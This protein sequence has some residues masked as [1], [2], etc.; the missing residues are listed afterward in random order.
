MSG[1][2]SPLQDFTKYWGERSNWAAQNNVPSDALNAV[3]ALDAQRLQSGLTPYTNSEAV[4]AL[5]AAS[6]RPTIGTVQPGL[7]PF[8]NIASDAQGILTGLTHLPATIAGY[9]EHPMGNVV[10]PIETSVG[11]LLKGHYKDALNAAAS[12]PLGFIPGVQTASGIAD[13]GLKYVLQ[14]PLYTALDTLPISAEGL[15]AGGIL[16]K[17]AGSVADKALSEG[18]RLAPQAEIMQEA[19]FPQEF[20]TVKAATQLRRGG[21]SGGYQDFYQNQITQARNAGAYQRLLDTADRPTHKLLATSYEGVLNAVH[22]ISPN[23]ASTLMTQIGRMANATEK[24]GFGQAARASASI[25]NMTAEKGQRLVDAM[26]KTLGKL[27]KE[28]TP[29]QQLLLRPALEYGL[30]PTQDATI[31]ALTDPNGMFKFTPNQIEALKQWMGIAK[32]QE[33]LKEQLGVIKKHQANTPTE[34]F[35][36]AH[37]DTTDPLARSLL[38]R[39]KITTTQTAKVADTLSAH[40]NSAEEHV[41]NYLN[42][43][44]DTRDTL[45]TEVS[46]HLAQLLEPARRGDLSVKELNRHWANMSEAERTATSAALRK[47]VQNPEIWKQIIDGKEVDLAKEVPALTEH[48][49]ALNDR[50]K[51]ADEEAAKHKAAMDR[52]QALRDLRDE[53]KAREKS[54]TDTYTERANAATDETA[55]AVLLHRSLMPETYGPRINHFLE[56]GEGAPSAAERRALAEVMREYKKA[57]NFD[58][59]GKPVS[60]QTYADMLKHAEDNIKT[61]QAAEEQLRAEYGAAKKDVV[62]KRAATRKRILDSGGGTARTSKLTDAQKAA[63]D[64]NAKNAR[65][66]MD[67]RTRERLV[68]QRD[69]AKERLDELLPHYKA[70][71]RDVA[72][73]SDRTRTPASLYRGKYSTPGLQDALNANLNKFAMSSQLTHFAEVMMPNFPSQLEDLYDRSGVTYT[74][75]GRTNTFKNLANARSASQRLSINIPHIAGLLHVY[76][77]QFD[78]SYDPAKSLEENMKPYVFHAEE[79]ARTIKEIKT[80]LR[81]LQRLL[82]HPKFST[83]EDVHNEVTALKA[84]IGSQK[85][86]FSGEVLKDLSNRSTSLNSTG[87]LG[88]RIK[89]AFIEASRGYTALNSYDKMLKDSLDPAMRPLVQ[90][91]ATHALATDIKNTIAP[92]QE[93]LVATAIAD[94]LLPAHMDIF[95]IG[96]ASQ[97]ANPLPPKFGTLDETTGRVNMSKDVLINYVRSL[98]PEQILFPHTTHEFEDVLK[99]FP[100]LEDLHNKVFFLQQHT[101]ELF[102]QTVA[103][104]KRED[105]MSALGAAEG[106]GEDENL[107][108]VALFHDLPLRTQK[109]LYA[110]RMEQIIS[111]FHTTH[112]E[113]AVDMLR[114]YVSELEKAKHY[115]ALSNFQFLDS[116]LDPTAYFDNVKQ[117]WPEYAANGFAPIYVHDP[118]ISAA[119]RTKLKISQKIQKLSAEHQRVNYSNAISDIF[120]ALHVQNYELVKNEALRA[121]AQNL[122]DQNLVVPWSTV[123]RSV[124]STNAFLKQYGQSAVNGAGER[125]LAPAAVEAIRATRDWVPFDIEK[126]FT[127]N[128]NSVLDAHQ[129]SA[130]YI[131]RDNLELFG[132]VNKDVLLRPLDFANGIFKTSVLALSPRFIAHLF[133]GGLTMG[134]GMTD[135]SHIKFFMKAA[136]TLIKGDPEGKL[137]NM[138]ANLPAH[139]LESGG[140][141]NILH[142]RQG[143]DMASIAMDAGGMRLFGKKISEMKGVEKAT[144]LLKWTKQIEEI[145]TR[146]HRLASMLYFEDKGVTDLPTLVRL[147]NRIYG[148]TNALS[149]LE[150]NIL[151]RIIPFYAFEAHILRYLGNYPLD[152][153]FRTSFLVNYA[154]QLQQDQNTNLPQSLDYLFPIINTGHGNQWYIDY[155]QWN[156]FRSAFNYLTLTGFIQGVNPLIQGLLTATGVSTLNGAATPYLPTAFDTLYASQQTTRNNAFYS[157]LEAT[158]PQSQIVDHFL[159]LTASAQ[160]LARYDPKYNSAQ[161]LA[162]LVNFPWLPQKINLMQ[163]AAKGS[164]AKYRQAVSDVSN[165]LKTGNFSILDRYNSD[166]PYSGYMVSAAQLKAMYDQAAAMSQAAPPFSQL[167]LT[168]IAPIQFIKKPRAPRL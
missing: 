26:Q 32:D 165:A 90:D 122:I 143:Q 43:L 89:R 150:R 46:N 6:G 25:V 81:T 64:L 53:L 59:G 151:R 117:H 9:F 35:V 79:M 40:S 82:R 111:E 24:L 100:P 166:V 37:G 63:R 157:V 112:G 56:T 17:M 34:A 93:G 129:P 156:P 19:N 121:I 154:H 164:V 138:A 119:E 142:F 155:R 10:N 44:K 103:D 92:V 148:D 126:S 88:G 141:A 136:A 77:H 13:N 98:T 29:E 27:S 87:Y 38:D 134:V 83:I 2:V 168:N 124:Q 118:S 39:P 84:A 127:D 15:S 45:D 131:H 85:D 145:I 96:D 99:Q 86:L 130:Y 149:P 91:M 137:A 60:T 114:Q 14:H 153:P 102:D 116:S 135:L 75:K 62:D 66:L 57:T 8:T 132:R 58:L 152:H 48:V 107:Q 36:E 167:G 104:M 68:I 7:N 61:K 5:S 161:S 159:H 163:Y 50:I 133:F 23:L 18:G 1:P 16:D 41:S 144:A 30:D 128:A 113:D 125:V 52:I 47:V 69:A 78:F 160:S 139:V 70:T 110:A 51:A 94:P 42:N 146:T 120:V 95:G 108:N 67:A 109:K 115:S 21:A 22:S 55:N 80:D 4:Q 31:A 28:F 162:S 72:K 140:D 33:A 105:S 97:Y 65:S 76:I 12:S 147:Q 73:I 71:A 3:Y 106:A 20:Q 158:I 49:K 54:L 101:Q 11:D 74:G 123:E